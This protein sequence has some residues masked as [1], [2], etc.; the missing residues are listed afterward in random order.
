MIHVFWVFLRQK[1]KVYVLG[2]RLGYSFRLLY[3]ETST[4]RLRGNGRQVNIDFPCTFF[5]PAPKI[6][7]QTW[8]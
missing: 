5:S 1:E 7:E 4:K 8:N 3:I 6:W 2:K